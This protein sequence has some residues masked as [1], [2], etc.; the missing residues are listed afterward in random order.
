MNIAIYSGNNFQETFTKAH[1]KYL[2]PKWLL[3][4]GPVPTHVNGQALQK[5]GIVNKLK[6]KLFFSQY[7]LLEY[8]FLEFLKENKPDLIF[9]EFGTYAANIVHLCKLYNIKMIAGFYGYDAFDKNV[10]ENYKS[11]YQELFN[12]S[13]SILTQ[14]PSIKNKLISLGCKEDIIT[15]NTCPPEKE[16]L[17]VV[18]DFDSKNIISVIRFVD[19]KAPHLCIFSFKKVLEVHPDATLI[20]AGDGPL[21]D[22]CRDIVDYLGLEKN[23]IF[24]GRISPEDQMKLYS[25]S[26]IYVQHSVTTS[27]GDMEGIPVSILE[28]GLAGLPVVSTFHSGIPEVVLHE[29]TGFL[30]AEKDIDAMADHLVK[31]LSDR[32]LLISTGKKAKEY[33]SN[34]YTMDKHIKGIFEMFEQVQSLKK[35]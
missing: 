33:I 28:A 15:I 26:A 27:Y 22:V 5:K 1:A 7:N 12:Y 23:V 4:G 14:S 29:E 24:K 31:L 13:S 3:S 10:L 34:N 9:V 6:H 2:N 18:P 30:V 16:F 25:E 21:L 8:A 17:S 19:K 20:L 11:R 32:E 35:I